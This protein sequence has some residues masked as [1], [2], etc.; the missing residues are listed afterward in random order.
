VQLT[1]MASGSASDF[2]SDFI[3]MMDGKVYA[4]TLMICDTY[5]LEQIRQDYGE[6]SFKNALDA[7]KTARSL[8]CHTGSWQAC[9]CGAYG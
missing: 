5:F 3:C 8:L 4:R 2:I 6:A 1:G 9:V 7:C